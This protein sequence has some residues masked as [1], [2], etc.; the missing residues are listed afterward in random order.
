MVQVFWAFVIPYGS[1]GYAV[2]GLL[3]HITVISRNFAVLRARRRQVLASESKIDHAF[4]PFRA[5]RR[6][7]R[8]PL[9]TITVERTTIAPRDGQG[10]VWIQ[11]RTE[12][13]SDH[14]HAV[15]GPPFALGRL[16]EDDEDK[17]EVTY[18]EDVDD[19]YGESGA[20]I[21]QIRVLPQRSQHGQAKAQ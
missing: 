20:S 7:G 19:E 18:K 3:V 1:G 17:G 2:F 5:G 13:T 21:H 15:P 6:K 4:S 8:S 14:H 11:T 12:T 16:E 10:G 9:D